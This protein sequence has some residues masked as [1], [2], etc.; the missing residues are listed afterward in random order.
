[1]SY[2][3]LQKLILGLT[4]VTIFNSSAAWAQPM[5]GSDPF[6]RLTQA[7]LGLGAFRSANGTP[8]ANYWQQQVD[9]DI[10]V[11]LMPEQQ[12][13]EASA[14]VHYHNRSPDTLNN[15]FFAL[16]HDAL[17]GASAAEF[18]LL[19][20]GEAARPVAVAR[21]QKTTG[22]AIESVQRADGGTLGWNVSDTLLHIRLPHPLESGEKIA[23]SMQWSLPLTDKQATTVRSGYETLDDGK[24]IFVAAQWFPRAVAY[25]DYAGWQ[26]KPF[27]QQGEFSTEFGRYRVRITAPE[28]F[29][30]AASGQL[31]NPKEV[32]DRQQFLQ[33]KSDSTEERWIVNEALAN[34]KRRQT[35]EES[36]QW[37]FTGEQLRDF[38]F[39]ASASFHWQIKR[40]SKGRRLQLFYPRE[41]A[42][43]WSKFGL[44]AI[45][46]TLQV[47]DE[48]TV[49][50]PLETISVVNAAG[51]GME[52]PGLATIATRPERMENTR[53]PSTEASEPLPPWDA[54]TKYDFIG[55]IIHE[56]G[57]NYLPMAIN[58]DEREWAWLDEG[59]VSF[60]EY[61]A[62]HAWEANF[63]VIY[64]EPRSVA[65]YM[66]SQ[67]H[68]P[69][70]TS[71]DSLDRK[72]ANAYNK[73]ASV[74]N[75][76]RHL[77]LSP[78][79][80][81]QA[82]RR[83]AV[84]WQGKR[85]TPG[86][87]FRA[88]ESSTGTDLSWFWRNWFFDA[89]SIDF[90][91]LA[92]ME[93]GTTLPQRSIDQPEPAALAYTAGS[94]SRFVVDQQPDLADTYTK[95]LIPTEASERIETPLPAPT[96]HSRWY[97]L[98]IAN[99]GL[100]LLPVPIRLTT[101]SGRAYRL[102]VPAQTWMR[103]EEGKL[104]LQ[105]PLPEH[106]SLSGIC[107]D[108]LWLTPDTDRSNN[109]IEMDPS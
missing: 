27:L 85:P 41:A 59:L 8:S 86:D 95:T 84:D 52:Y 68:Q 25:T 54:L 32:L 100:G 38:A 106:E 58:T 17:K 101:A 1:M 103:T 82:L 73:T 34:L 30:I 55:S 104:S 88:M 109:C 35:T 9:Y 89:A 105:L 78:E 36:K 14:V 98:T 13:L 64:G 61:R 51:I 3:Q 94:I 67:A 37:F 45:D 77:V 4:A 50:L 29:V 20:S 96:E 24:R 44:P 107:I 10:D 99:S 60:I 79:D 70:M 47:F 5:A 65:G 72:I 18:R 63:D 92:L 80:F 75:M 11:S 23:L 76:L 87:F 74:L 31:R 91:V 7:E 102:Q 62:E 16:D 69:I 22:F 90:S 71:A 46:H 57:H 43:L 97:Q 6:A 26:L 39:S 28:N 21:N 56:V 108:P 48:A 40:D 12:R 53:E 81:D 2:P 19:A 49:P 15:L 42:S 83:F 33:W 66:A 93:N